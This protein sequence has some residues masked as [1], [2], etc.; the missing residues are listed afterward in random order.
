MPGPLNR[1]NLFKLEIATRAVAAQALG[2]KRSKRADTPTDLFLCIVDHYEPQVNK[3][4]T[5]V[6]RGRVEDWLRRYPELARAH[7]DSEGR[8][9]PHSFFYPWD[10]YDAWELTRILELCADGYGEVDIH[11]HHRDD[12]EA[13]LRQKLRDAV[14]VFHEHGALSQWPDGKPA[15][16][17]I[18]GNWALANSRCENGR[19]FCGVNNE[20]ELL[21]KEGC[22][23]DF[24]F[25]AWPHTAQPRQMNSIYYAKAD[26]LRPK[27][28]DRGVPA[29]SGQ[30]QQEGLLLIQGPLVPY[31]AGRGRAPRLAM[32]DSDLAHYARY[33]P[34]RMDRWV[35]AGIHVHGRPDRVFIKLHSHGAEDQNRAMMLGGDLDALFA[36]AEAR[37]NDGKRYR[38]HYVTAREM[39]NIVKATEAGIED[40]APA[41]DFILP[42]PGMLPQKG[43]PSTTP[44]ESERSLSE[45][46]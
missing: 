8:V 43:K 12:T 14:R 5:E 24:T 19:N 33:S 39:F 6:A 23:A 34:A 40:M 17:F 31:L 10:E 18:H 42:P 46:V 35:Q 4:S 16:G 11:L 7:R 30:T 41:R 29:Q 13:T 28:Y 37:Y 26:A 9:P 25:P 36:D 1:K 27:S 38:L 15:W 2:P 20:V 45:I 3:P 44:S 21:Q 22:Y 32:E